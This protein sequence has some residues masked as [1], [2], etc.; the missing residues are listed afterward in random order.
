MDFNPMK[1]VLIGIF[2]L[3]Y[4]NNVAGGSTV[5]TTEDHTNPL[6]N[7]YTTD[8]TDADDSLTN[9]IPPMLLGGSQNDSICTGPQCNI[10]LTCPSS[11]CNINNTNNC[12]VEVKDGKAV[13]KCNCNDSWIGDQCD[14]FDHCSSN[15]C[16]NNGTCEISQ[17][18]THSSYKCQCM[19]GDQTKNCR[20]NEADDCTYRPP[21]STDAFITCIDRID[22]RDLICAPG[23]TNPTDG[24]GDRE[25]PTTFCTKYGQNCADEGYCKPFCNVEVC[26]GTSN[27]N[28]TTKP[29]PDTNTTDDCEMRFAD[30]YTEKN[31]SS[32]DKLFDGNDDIVHNLTDCSPFFDTVCTGKFGNGICDPECDN[33]DCLYDGWYCTENHNDTLDKQLLGG[34]V[35]KFARHPKPLFQYKLSML[36]RT[37]L[38]VTLD[39][40]GKTAYM[41]VRAENFTTVANVTRF[42]AGA[43]AKLPYLIAYV[44]DVFVCEA[45]MWNPST[46]CSKKCGSNCLRQGEEICHWETGACLHGCNDG[47]Y[48]GTCSMPCPP[49]CKDKCYVKDGTPLCSECKPVFFLQTCNAT[50]D[51]HCQGRMCQFSSGTCTCSVGR[52]WVNQTN[53]CQ[54][55]HGLFGNSCTEKCNTY[56]KDSGCNEVS[57]ACAIGCISGYYGPDCSK[58]CVGC[59]NCDEKGT[60]PLKPDKNTAPVN[61]AGSDNT[62]L[63]VGVVVTLLL[64]PIIIL[65]ACCWWAHARSVWRVPDG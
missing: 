42:L 4:L 22:G 1:L 28:F 11:Y 50:C 36:T 62:G 29:F 55:Q 8:V 44:A 40:S 30:G 14:V 48:G 58:K 9:T 65:V 38:N 10:S 25:N 12:T 63:I 46:K 32:E 24:C 2:S 20:L 60:C 16:E 54:C 18:T 45:G 7:I 17:N 27:C 56:C 6:D 15:P 52:V 41:K 13:Y 3:S 19:T 33:A 39:K 5:Q 47:V 43:I 59:D 26:N 57:G 23:H 64:V 53:S 34:V 21:I 37:F 49:G 35:I 31:C 61:D 51:I